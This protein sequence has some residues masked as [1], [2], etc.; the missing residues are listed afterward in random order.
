[1][2]HLMMGHDRARALPVCGWIGLAAML[3]LGAKAT[4]SAA[5]AGED[6]LA[7]NRWVKVEKTR[8]A[9]D[10]ALASAHRSALKRL[11]PKIDRRS[12]LRWCYGQY[13]C[14]PETGRFYALTRT[15][16]HKSG[17]FCYDPKAGQWAELKTE[18]TPASGP[19]RGPL[20]WGSMCYM[21]HLRKILLFGGCSGVLGRRDPGTWL[22]DPAAKRWERLEP[23]VQPLQRANSQLVYDPVNRMAVVFGGD[24]LDSLLADTWIFDGRKWARKK[25]KVGPSPRA[26]HALLWLP[27]ARK[28]LLLGGYGYSSTDKSGRNVYRSLPLDAWAYDVED[29]RW[30][31]VTRFAGAGKTPPGC[32]AGRTARSLRAAATDNDVLLL[33]AGRAG[34]WLCRLDVSAPD[35]VGGKK[36]GVTSDTTELRTGCYDPEW[37]S[38]GPPSPSA[39]KLARELR[40]VKPN[41]W[42]RRAPAPRRPALV[43]GAWSSAIY[44]PE[45]DLIVRFTGGHCVYSGTAPM[46]YHVKTGR[47]SIPYAPE[48]ALDFCSG[49]T[50]FCRESFRGN[51]W[52]SG[53]TRSNTVYDPL[54][55]RMVYSNRTFTYFLD[56]ATGKWSRTSKPSP[57]ATETFG[58]YSHVCSTPKGVLA[59][60]PTGRRRPH[61]LY[62]LDPEKGTWNRVARDAQVPST[63]FDKHAMTYDSKRKRVLLYT[64]GKDHF[65]SYSLVKDSLQKVPVRGIIK[66]LPGNLRESVY[67]PESDAVLHAIRLKDKDGTPQWLL[68]DCGREEWRGI[69]LAGTGPLGKP[70]DKAYSYDNG[71]ALMHDPQ[72][73]LVWALDSRNR[74]YVLKPVWPAPAR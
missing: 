44:C 32:P 12:P 5:L 47:F 50:L 66:Q 40:S 17:T 67:L 25:P 28:V 31:F 68:Y 63:G 49:S 34:D 22:F 2:S 59:W 33:R 18:L 72:R 7:A 21:L 15:G 73:D 60:A 20:Y 56:P 16:K 55:K 71:L 36:H 58:M 62:L 26:G 43:E 41:T 4:P 3:A 65:L 30:D 19:E 29:D 10:G 69:G 37:Y 54:S 27:K 70:S 23:E 8:L 46:T 1:M 52:M 6:P 38:G 57:F 48:F 45:Q 13:A 61:R 24:H 9:T 53:H 74:V 35:A 39:E 11:P 42:M 51:P 64:A 14:V